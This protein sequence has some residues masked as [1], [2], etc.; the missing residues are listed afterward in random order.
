M[1]VSAFSSMRDIVPRYVRRLLPL[2]GLVSGRSI[3]KAIDRAGQ[4]AGFDPDL[5]SPV[6]A[7]ARTDASVLLLHGTLDQRVPASHS[8]AIRDAAAGACELKLIDGATHLSIMA[9]ESGQTVIREA[10]DWFDR[11]EP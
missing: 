4:R 3:T 7:I 11:L 1:A 9:G 8:A 10:A 6:A 2:G 5:A